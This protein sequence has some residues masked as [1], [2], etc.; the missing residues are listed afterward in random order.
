MSPKAEL[1][2]AQSQPVDP[3]DTVISALLWNADALYRRLGGERERGDDT[4][5][6][7]SLLDSLLPFTRDEGPFSRFLE[8]LPQ[9]LGS[10]ILLP[11]LFTRI[12]QTALQPIALP[13]THENA[14]SVGKREIEILQEM[15]KGR[16]KKE[17]AE[18]LF[19]SPG[20]VKKHF[21]NLYHKLEVNSPQE[22]VAKA[23]AL[24]LLKFDFQEFLSPFRD[25][26][27]FDLSP[28]A[29]M[30]LGGIHGR[31]SSETAEAK[32]R[33]A[34]LGLYLFLL[35]PSLEA[36]DLY[37]NYAFPSATPGEGRGIVCEIAPSGKII[38][39]LDAGDRVKQPRALTC[40]PPAAADHG[41]RPSHLFLV[42]GDTH[43]NPLNRDCIVE[44]TPEGEYVRSFTGGEHLSA[45]LIGSQNLA[46][47]PE[48]RLLATSSIH[49]DAVLE[50]TEGGASVRRYIEA[51]PYGGLAVDGLGR[52]YIAGG[53]GPSNAVQ[54][55][56]PEGAFLH[57]VG[58]AER[59]DYQGVAIDEEGNLFVARPSAH[60]VEVYGPEETLRKNIVGPMN[61]PYRLVLLPGCRLCVLDED[62]HYLKLF[63]TA[64]GAFLS[65]I[66]APPR[67]Q[68]GCTAPGP[69]GILYA[70][71]IQE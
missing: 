54:V 43:P 23:V 45:R 5:G 64:S 56:S 31:R 67:T 44:L 62:R 66:E 58:D 11:S 16:S 22:A 19:I 27:D 32:R 25:R 26:C 13:T 7:G 34:A 28:F 21:S 69:N 57:A 15:A 24:G 29:S 38:R 6:F 4:S 52:V 37:E 8:D 9:A 3:A 41:F 49:T 30:L 60:R 71:G 36:L 59:F 2:P 46:F 55:F 33:L 18:H 53:R 61:R 63:D 68:F 14:F 39:T 50:F 47:T 70:A 51:V 12:F 42:E 40:A 20:T 48:G 1:P 65:V 17:I 10:G 35:A